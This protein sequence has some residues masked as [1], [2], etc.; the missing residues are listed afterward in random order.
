MKYLIEIADEAELACLDAALYVYCPVMN[1]DEET[2]RTV[3]RKVSNALP[4]EDL[5]GK[6]VRYTGANGIDYYAIVSREFPPGTVFARSGY[7]DED[8]GQ[9]L[10]GGTYELAEAE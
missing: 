4:V 5:V 8:E 6:R 7:H 10:D 9:I 2:R 1:E 3:R